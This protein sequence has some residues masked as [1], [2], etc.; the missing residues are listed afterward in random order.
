MFLTNL[1]LLILNMI[2]LIDELTE[3]ESKY[4]QLFDVNSI[5]E[6]K[7]EDKDKED[8]IT[9]SGGLMKV[10]E[11]RYS[12]LSK[13]TRSLTPKQKYEIGKYS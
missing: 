10:N 8:S 5:K 13:Q 4:P 6:K 11:G 3:L 1:L 12:R 2:T 7:N 9:T